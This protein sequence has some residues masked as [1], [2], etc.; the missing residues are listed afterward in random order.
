M[1]SVDHFV[2]QLRTAVLSE[3]AKQ[4]VQSTLQ[5]AV[6]DPKKLAV[7]LPDYPDDDTVLYEDDTLSVWHV[8]FMPGVTVPPHEHLIPTFIGLYQGRERNDFYQ[9]TAD[10]KIK[11]SGQQI[12]EPGD[13]LAMGA[14]GI[15]SVSC[16]GAEPCCGLHVY[17]GSL[18]TIER[19]LFHPQTYERMALPMRITSAYRV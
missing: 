17:L 14:E 8:R 10:G 1:F 16:V 18:T 9:P 11:H 3:M 5:Q 13:L 15:H 19:S 7:D 6:A 12:L 2:N 4:Q